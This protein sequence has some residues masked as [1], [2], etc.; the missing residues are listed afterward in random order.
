ML[1]STSV[2]RSYSSAIS[3]A[4]RDLSIRAEV[5][6][7]MEG[8]LGDLD[9]WEWANKEEKLKN[10]LEHARAQV[11]ALKDSER[12]LLQVIR[13]RGATICAVR[14]FLEGLPAL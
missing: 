6:T 14:G 4:M 10:E 7:V 1:V 8:M 3:E 12:T 13:C 11:A 9:A 5:G 2:A